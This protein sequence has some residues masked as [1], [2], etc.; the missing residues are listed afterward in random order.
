MVVMITEE[1]AEAEVE[2]DT[3][4]TEREVHQA[5]EAIDL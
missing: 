4:N 3:R 5:Q 2:I 1:E